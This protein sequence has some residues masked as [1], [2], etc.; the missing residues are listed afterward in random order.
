MVAGT[1]IISAAWA[2]V[3]T[4]VTLPMPALADVPAVATNHTIVRGR[5]EWADGKP[6]A[7]VVLELSATLQVAQPGKGTLTTT[8]TVLCDDAGRFQHEFPI[9][10][11][12]CI[13]T[14]DSFG[15]LAPVQLR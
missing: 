14:T 8:A 12:Q 5:A 10:A 3:G 4:I 15:V 13:A 11:K 1:K 7:G 9:P 2:I 6:A